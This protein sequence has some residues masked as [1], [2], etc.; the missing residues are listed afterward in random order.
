MTAL[1]KTNIHILVVDDEPGMRELLRFE[2]SNLGYRV[3]TAG[4]GEEG[5]EI[6]KKEKIQLVISD[7]KMAKMD[8]I[9][10]L[11]NIKAIKPEI[12]VILTT[13][14][15]TSEMAVSAMKKGAYDF[16]LKPFNLDEMMALVEKVVEKNEMRVLLALYEASRTFSFTLETEHLYSQIMEVVGKLFLSDEIS[17]SLFGESKELEVA[18][19]HGELDKKFHLRVA[20]KMAAFAQAG[21]VKDFLINGNNWPGEFLGVS[22]HTDESSRIIIPLFWQK[23]FFGVLH[24]A[25]KNE[26]GVFLAAELQSLSIFGSEVVLAVQ[27]ATLYRDLR[28]SVEELKSSN[29]RL[30]QTQDQLLQTE[31]LASI[32]RLVS[33]VA[34]ELNN[35][36][37][38]ILGYTQILQETSVGKTREQL[39]IIYEQS[40]RCR[41]I[42]QDLLA[43]ARNGEAP[44]RSFDIL[45]LIE[46]ILSEIFAE[47]ETKGIQ[48]VKRFTRP[49]PFIKGNEEQVK[50]VLFS[51]LRNAV[52]AV[53]NIKTHKKEI[54]ITVTNNRKELIIEVAD[55]G[56]GIPKEHLKTIFDP[57]FTT[58]DVGKGRGLGL[59]FSYGVMKA[60][61]GV[62]TVQSD[63]G[64]GA[65]FSIS[66][67]LS[68]AE[69]API[70]SQKSLKS[71][72]SGEKKL[73]LIEDE[74]S[75]MSFLQDVLAKR[76]YQIQA[77]SNGQSALD[78]ISEQ[79][80]DLIICDYRIPKLNGLDLFEKVKASKPSLA[81]R[82]LFISG[83]GSLGESFEEKHIPFLSKPFT[84]T[85]LLAAV[86][87]QLAA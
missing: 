25:R 16:V 58:R 64:K 47:V 34:H 18:A 31:K 27:N 52:Q 59:S 69:Q 33:G 82:F 53:E 39:S 22:S 49:C 55:N 1:H 38:A 51:I 44:F 41:T 12:E 15:G 80:F 76:P 24:V 4:S 11:E 5:L 20:E 67:P 81:K 26:K 86:D 74:E 70:P 87:R 3:T 62:I 57:F 42:I 63:E 2:L 43:F 85:D 10:L 21:T 46:Q 32:G 60:H 61:G 9:T 72:I 29:Q 7:I 66:F 8:G 13:G 17:I 77:V 35:P 68:D 65:A 83:S 79:P 50:R 75:V 56:A 37:T 78:L 45:S 54:K 40:Q 30:H 6:V 36:L 19:F 84:G 71:K 73:L 23:E 48:I 14:Y 28:S